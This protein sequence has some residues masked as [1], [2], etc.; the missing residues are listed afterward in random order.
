M[1]WGEIIESIV[2]F[3]VG[4]GLGTL[5]TN[6]VM[7]KYKRQAAALENEKSALVNEAQ[8]IANK[9]SELQ[10]W[11]EITEERKGRIEELRDALL[12]ADERHDRIVHTKNSEIDRLNS[13]VDAL[14]K[15]IAKM[16]EG[17]AEMRDTIDNLRSENTALSIFRCDTVSC[18]KR[19][20]PFAYQ[21][22]AL[23]IAH[24]VPQLNDNI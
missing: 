2:G 4:G 5:I 18:A 12:K 17:E 23:G 16:R 3:V 9:H 21:I 8:E 20:P 11:R 10:E 7:A 14:Y 6:L 13:K 24:T 1:A 22:P 15:E 19:V